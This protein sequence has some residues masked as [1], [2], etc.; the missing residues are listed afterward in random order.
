MKERKNS[1]PSLRIHLFDLFIWAQPS[2]SPF[3][4][5]RPFHG[6]LMQVRCVEHGRFVLK[7]RAANNLRFI[8]MHR[9]ESLVILF[10][11][12]PPP[13]SS[14]TRLTRVDPLSPPSPW[15]ALS[16]LSLHLLE[17]G[18]RGKMV[19][20]WN[21]DWRTER[22]SNCPEVGVEKGWG[23]RERK[24]RKEGRRR[25]AVKGETARPG[26]RSVEVNFAFNICHEG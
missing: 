19:G 7:R 6:N 13:F 1:L 20:R 23:G 9:A 15:S 21:Y 4:S 18:R 25:D 14:K 10:P 3:P 11:P 16:F 5:P 2:L 22:P 26:H 24:R 17:M 12:F 8:E